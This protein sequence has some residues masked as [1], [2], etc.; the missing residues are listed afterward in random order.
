MRAT[1]VARNYAETL[2]TLAERHSGASAIDEFGR[3][4]DE[5][6]TLLE[7]EPLI[8]EFLETPLVGVEKKKQALRHTLEGRVP[9]LF[10][11]FLLVVVEKRRAA[12]LHEIAAEYHEMVD[13]MRGRI[14][15]QITLAREPDSALQSDIRAS[16][17]RMLR[18]EVIP[19]FRVD[20]DL[21]GGM[22]IRVGDYV[23]DGSLRRRA[24]E[25]RRRLLAM[26]MP[27]QPSI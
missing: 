18:R 19:E 16:L 27:G 13:Q 15:A 22:V 12:H 17:Q 10:L 21:I 7:R 25:L 5:L 1:V 4:L 26:E 6:V 3:A 11:R 24:S 2:L 20:Q 23:L 8:R 14:R 9:A